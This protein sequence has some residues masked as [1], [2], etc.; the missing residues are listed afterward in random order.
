MT[1]PITDIGSKIET[2]W[3]DENKL[4]FMTSFVKIDLN[5]LANMLH[6]NFRGEKYIIM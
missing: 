6:T 3:N 1:V 4:K 5:N 2:F